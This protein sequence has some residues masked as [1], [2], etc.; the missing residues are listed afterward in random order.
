M[1]EE[2]EK[3]LVAEEIGEEPKFDREKVDEI[4]EELSKGN[5]NPEDFS[6]GLILRLRKR[7]EKVVAGPFV[8]PFD[9]D[10]TVA[11]GEIAHG[12]QAIGLK[13]GKAVSIY[14]DNTGEYN[15]H[16]ILMGN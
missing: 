3:K 2:Q 9:V 14:V 8:E 10:M 4:K 7:G 16:F 15:R 12:F 1:S 11:I 5:I 6:S 13:T